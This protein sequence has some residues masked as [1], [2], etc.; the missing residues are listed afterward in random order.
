[1]SIFVRTDSTDLLQRT[2]AAL[3]DRWQHLYSNE[4]L[5]NDRRLELTEDMIDNF[6]CFILV[7]EQ[8][9]EGGRLQLNRKRLQLIANVE[10]QN[11]G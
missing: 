2:F 10:H 8:K 9:G 5:G 3:N 4:R 11:I 6:L 1:M 7:G